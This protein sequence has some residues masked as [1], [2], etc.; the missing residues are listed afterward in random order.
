M[1]ENSSSQMGR[2]CSQCRTGFLEDSPVLLGLSRLALCVLLFM[3]KF[4]DFPYM[5]NTE[6]AKQNKQ[7][8]PSSHVHNTH[9]TR[10]KRSRQ[11]KEQVH[12]CYF[13]FSQVKNRFCQKAHGLYFKRFEID[14]P[15]FQFWVRY[16]NSRC[17]ELDSKS[18][19]GHETRDDVK[20]LSKLAF[21]L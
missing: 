1:E 3:E 21:W 19:S 7:Q 2:F 6:L 18:E 10:E 11:R 15:G 16:W 12:R 14:I 9:T 20:Y 4:R 5:Q 17:M 13:L 8:R